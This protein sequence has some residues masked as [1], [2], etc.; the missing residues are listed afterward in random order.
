MTTNKL[1]LVDAPISLDTELS[2]LEKIS[3][4]NTETQA[5]LN[6]IQTHKNDYKKS[7][8]HAGYFFLKGEVL[9]NLGRYDKALDSYNEA[10]KKPGHAFSNETVSLRKAIC[11]FHKGKGDRG[12]NALKDLPDTAEK[13]SAIQDLT[14]LSLEKFKHYMAH[15]NLKEA[16]ALFAF[17]E[18]LDE[19]FDLSAAAQELGI[20]AFNKSDFETAE[21]FLLKAFKAD[22]EENE[23]ERMKWAEKCEQKAESYLKN[24]SYH[25][26]V[27]R[28]Q[29]FI[30]CATLMELAHKFDPYDADI[31]LKLGEILC[32]TAEAIQTF[33]FSGADETQYAMKAYLLLERAFDFYHGIY[34]N[35]LEPK[36]ASLISAFEAKAVE[37]NELKKAE[38]LIEKT[39]EIY[40]DLKLSRAKMDHKIRM[41]TAKVDPQP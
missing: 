38:A 20:A 35:N 24:P 22:T 28:A 12:L 34:A 14:I 33:N 19:T 2:H 26:A 4:N 1:R 18:E 30:D 11:T 13:R 31:C 17:M 6:R 10:T 27:L 23:I 9:F 3:K 5:Y 16:E 25:D 15:D 29:A 41:I 40:P 37:D 8:K 21:Y 7:L 32:S 36:N 39:F